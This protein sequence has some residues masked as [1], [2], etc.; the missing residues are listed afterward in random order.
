MAKNLR[1]LQG[2]QLILQPLLL[3]LHALQTPLPGRASAGPPPRPPRAPLPPGAPAPPPAS[4]F[5]PVRQT[6]KWVKLHKLHETIGPDS[7][8]HLAQRPVWTGLVQ[9]GETDRTDR[10]A[11]FVSVDTKTGLDRSSNKQRKLRR[12]AKTDP[13]QGPLMLCFLHSF[14]L[15]GEP[16]DRLDLRQ[17]L[18]GGT[19]ALIRFLPAGIRQLPL[20]DLWS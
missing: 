2:V 1:L 12:T 17:K 5:R 20:T 16:R 9:T 10:T 13:F 3:P 11:Q 7:S 8:F 15:P 4:L 18:V 19:G 14:P 6:T